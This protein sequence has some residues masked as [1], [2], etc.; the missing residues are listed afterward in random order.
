MLDELIGRK[1]AGRYQI[2][3]K[4]GEG[5]MASVFKAHDPNLDRDVAIKVLPPHLVTEDASFAKRFQQEAKIAAKLDHPNI[6]PVYDFGVEDGYSYIVM[7]YVEGGKTMRQLMHSR[8]FTSEQLISIVTQMA[9]ALAYAHERGVIHRDV[10]PANVLLEGQRV[11]LSDFGIAKISEGATTKLTGTNVRMG[12]PSYMSP[13][14]G[15][16]KSVDHRTD[17]YALGVILYELLTGAIPHNADTPVAIAVKRTLEPPPSPR[18]INPDIS[19]PMEQV[20]LHALA[21]K[22]DDRYD[23]MVKFSTDLKKVTTQVQPEERTISSAIPLPKELP[24]KKKSVRRFLTVAFAI[25]MVLMAL[26]AIGQ[27]KSSNIEP[28]GITEVVTE[29]VAILPTPT[30]PLSTTNVELLTDT[31]T[32]TSSTSLLTNTATSV[33]ST[34]APLPTDTPQPTVTPQSTVTPEPTVTPELP[35]TPTNTL[36]ALPMPPQLTPT[37]S[38][39][40]PTPKPLPTHTST[41]V[42]FPS[43]TLLE[44]AEGNTISTGKSV[45]FRWQWSGQLADTMG[46][47]VL[48]WLDGVDKIHYG[49]FGADETKK[50]MTTKGDGTYELSFDPSS[51]YSVQQH[52]T[53]ENY[54]WTV[55]LVELQ[56]QYRNLNIEAT[57]RRIIITLPG[58]G[59]KGGGNNGGGGGGGGGGTF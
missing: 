43:P 55:S 57:Q 49:A 1:L 24:K 9:D 5:G 6:L 27:K 54:R 48:I 15:H 35:V 29:T 19:K 26:V 14:Q 34:V 10:K 36:T 12:T 30:T 40:T 17:I 47:E 32:L 16:G 22:P 20:V 51:A 56:P 13:E 23:S 50:L 53:Q 44:P 11:F 21:T 41:P 28:T 58:G 7:R 37:I 25:I 2:E 52:G 18:T 45:L 42:N 59:S 46:F 31:N 4:I 3:K 8:Q 39:P 38:L 33:T